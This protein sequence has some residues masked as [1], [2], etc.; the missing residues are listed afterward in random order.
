[1]REMSRVHS[2]KR[3]SVQEPWVPDITQYPLFW[4]MDRQT[5][6]C[7]RK[8]DRGQMPEYQAHAR[9]FPETMTLDLRTVL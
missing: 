8:G 9:Y 2:A 5:G 1:M 6:S 4:L 7:W 3:T